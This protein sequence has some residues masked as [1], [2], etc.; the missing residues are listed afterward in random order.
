M[1][2]LF[3]AFPVA[4]D[5]P[6]GGE[7]QLLKS[8]EALESMGVEVLLYDMWHPQFDQV[9]VV[10]H[11]SVQGGSSVFCNYVKAKGLP[12]VIS[13]ILWITEESYGAGI[14]PIHEIKHLLTI[15][16]ALLP[17]SQAE[18]DGLASIFEIPK[19]KFFPIVN[20]VDDY[21]LEH[22][23]DPQLFLN[24]YNIEP[25]FLLN[26]ANIEPRKNQLKLAEAVRELDIPLVTLGNIRDREYFDRCVEVG[27]G[28]FRYLGYVEHHSPL[29]LSAYR[30][31]SVCVLP[32]LLETPG[33]AALEAAAK[34][35][36]VVVTQ[37]GCTQ[38]YF[39]NGGVTYVD[40]QSVE[41]I[42][43]GIRQQLAAPVSHD[44]AQDIVRSFT[45][46]KAAQQLLQVYTQS[47]QSLNSL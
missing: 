16:D 45:W 19:E 27:Q 37:E 20:G 41:S 22:D 6:G 32:S 18:A 15:A 24:T 39:G 10:H 44:L 13:P 1:R 25:P 3:N 47:V 21:F 43:Q 38:E 2:V 14:Y 35:A 42:R 11:F 34:G 36:K 31:C 26:V 23:A 9:D 33:L 40:P 5:C 8:K 46:K 7:V 12:L 17:N 30:A 28:C 29:L 4:F